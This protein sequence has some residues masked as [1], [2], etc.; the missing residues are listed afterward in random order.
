METICTAILAIAAIAAITTIAAIAVIEIE[1]F[2]SQRSQR[3]MPAIITIESFNGNMNQRIER[4][5]QSRYIPQYHARA[6]ELSQIKMDTPE[7]A[8]NFSTD[9]F[10]EEVQKYT[11]LYNKY[12]NN[13]KDKFKKLNS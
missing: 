10:M 7:E 4:S 12:S 9:V 8:S 13:F 11:C 6:R 1:N 3:S 5:Q 2:L